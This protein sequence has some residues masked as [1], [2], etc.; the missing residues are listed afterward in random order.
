ME[1]MIEWEWFWARS[2]LV[3]ESLDVKV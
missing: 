3:Y 1:Q 2:D